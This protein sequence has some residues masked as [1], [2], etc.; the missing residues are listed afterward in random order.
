[1]E[2]VAKAALIHDA[3][4]ILLIQRS[5]DDDKRPGELDFPGGGIESGESPRDAMVREIGEEVG[6][7]VTLDDVSLYYAHTEL[8]HGVSLTRLAFRCRVTHPAVTLSHEHE[9]YQW[10]PVADAST[11]FPHKVWTAS[12]DYALYHDLFKSE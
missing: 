3:G 2:Q 8:A 11:V 4:K 9:T 10:V 12:V 1:M 6:I 7:Q 5:H